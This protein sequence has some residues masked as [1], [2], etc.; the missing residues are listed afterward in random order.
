MEDVHVELK[1]R[2]AR[3][4]KLET[5][6]QRGTGLNSTE[7]ATY[8]ILVRTIGLVHEQLTL[9]AKKAINI[10]LTLRNWLIGYHI[11]EYQLKG[12]DRAQYG[13][14]LVEVLSEELGSLG[15]SSTGKRQLY[16][17]LAFYRTYPQI[18]RSVTALLPKEL[19]DGTDLDEKMRSLT[20]Q[21]GVT[22]P[23][24]L[25]SQLS[26]THLEQLVRLDDKSKREFYEA[27]CVQG[28]WSVRE[29]KRQ[30]ATLYYERTALSTNKEAIA[31]QN[32]QR[33]ER[34]NSRFPVRDP[35]MF[36]FLGLKSSEVMGESDL[37]DALLDRLQAFLLELGHGFCFE[38]RQKRILI[39]DTH[40]FV[41]L[42]FYHRILKCHVLVELKIDKFTHEHIGQ[43]NTYVSWYADNQMTHGDNPPVGL[44]LCTEKDT[45]VAKYALAGMNNQLFVSRYQVAL[46]SPEEL[47]ELLSAD[48]R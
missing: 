23:E 47:Q 33:A 42:V 41:D 5:S 12:A 16:Q 36:E 7:E 17:Y 15:V 35:Y 34:E 46:P 6:D 27:N 43:L 22:E 10:S 11:D 40:N 4:S 21:S 26:Y 44:L 8:P 25:L 19:L 24:R 13:D 1:N 48:D 45:T 20:A 14:R 38:A 31:N 18:V 3:S 37:E 30:I 28:Q 9:R 32:H 39:G 2:R 29:L